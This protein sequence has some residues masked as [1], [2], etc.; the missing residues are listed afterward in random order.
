MTQKMNNTNTNN[1]NVSPLNRTTTTTKATTTWVFGEG[2]PLW[3]SCGGGVPLERAPSFCET[4]EFLSEKK[5][6]VSRV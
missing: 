5:R 6:I 3:K 1:L 2:D 4:N